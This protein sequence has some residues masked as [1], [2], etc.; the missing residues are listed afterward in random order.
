M[1]WKC[2][3][4]SEAIAATTPQPGIRPVNKPLF[5]VVAAT[6]TSSSQVAALMLA[7]LL[8]S[9]SGEFEV[10]VAVAGQLATA[11]FATWAVSVLVC[12]PLSDSFGRRP[13]VLTG[14]FLMA[15]STLACFFVSNIYIF[16]AL[17]IIT[18]FGGGM[19]PPNTAATVADVI[20]PERRAQ[21]VGGMMAANIMAGSVSVP[22]LA[23]LADGAGWRYAFAATGL[24]LAV[25]LILSFIWFPADSRERVR[26]FSFMPRYKALL[27]MG[28]FRVAV[29]VMGSH[30]I[31]FWAM[32][33]YLPALLHQNY[34]MSV[35]AV[36][37]PLGIAAATQVLGSFSTGFVANSK[38]RSL[39]LAG[40]CAIGGFCGL[41]FF[42]LPVGVWIAVAAVAVG[43]GL[44]SIPFPTLV[45]VSTEYS[46]RSRAT[47]IG[48]LGLGNQGGGAGGA[49]LGGALLASVGFAGVGYMCM[50]LAIVAA[51]ASLGFML[52]PA[53][54]GEQCRE[55]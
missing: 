27:S 33:N 26:D 39:L 8:V 36:A 53:N 51:I 2:W 43:S 4:R 44:L 9:I 22:L 16:I 55:H 17:R 1:R 49:A 23:L 52:Q 34:G 37:V 38:H 30:R 45:A 12:G 3:K 42:S 14:L 20:S 5:L 46:G 29:V 7:P 47:G 6:G 50:G 13:I 54:Q 35:G 19:I 24:L 25:G 15:A 10:S 40:G 21:A 31:V 48:L 32:V 18:G 28:F 11:T 41:V